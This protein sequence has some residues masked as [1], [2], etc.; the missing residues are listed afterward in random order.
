[1]IYILKCH[2]VL[3]SYFYD[4]L[5]FSISITSISVHCLNSVPMF[6]SF[7]KLAKEEEKKCERENHNHTYY[8]LT[9]VEAWGR[10]G[11]KEIIK[12]EREREREKKKSDGLDTP[13]WGTL[14]FWFLTFLKP[15]SPRFESPSGP[16][17]PS[18]SF[19]SFHKSKVQ[20]QTSF[21]YPSKSLPYARNKN[22]NST[23][24]FRF[25]RNLMWGVTFEF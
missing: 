14:L 25:Y 3:W 12:R 13:P 24:Q 15:W 16:L 10:K 21:L 1:M 19:E 11:K 23:Y 2:S 22:K 8:T 6:W 4:L 20:I 7:G 18:R 9:K 17:S 5:F